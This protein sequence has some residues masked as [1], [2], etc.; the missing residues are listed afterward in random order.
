MDGTQLGGTADGRALGTPLLVF[1]DPDQEE[2]CLLDVGLG[3]ASLGQRLSELM[4]GGGKCGVDIIETL[5]TEGRP[6]D[7][8]CQLYVLVCMLDKLLVSHCD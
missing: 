4:S 1:F 2:A 3:Q 5:S 7:L 6:E 8:L